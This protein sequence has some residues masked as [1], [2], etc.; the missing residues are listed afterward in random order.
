MNDLP[1]CLNCRTVMYADDTTLISTAKNNPELQM[2]MQED[3]HEAKQWFEKN[4]LKLNQQKTEVLTFE[5]DR[6]EK[7][8]PAV[9]LLGIYIDPRLTWRDHIEWLRTSLARATYAV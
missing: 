6:W 1:L 4:A 3:L 7:A 9:R 8:G 5:M 2:R